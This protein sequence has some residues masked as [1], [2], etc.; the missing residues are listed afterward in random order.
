MS[1]LTE[2][3][4]TFL[5]EPKKKGFRVVLQNRDFMKLWVGQLISNIGS[6]IGSLALLF[7]AYALTGSELAMAG[8]AMVQVIPLILFS[9]LI[10]VYVDRWDRK[11]IM[12]VS[13]FS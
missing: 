1:E 13:L 5:E 4:E 11:K 8:L 6:S 10:G 7:F 2:V 12:I 3:E 9:G